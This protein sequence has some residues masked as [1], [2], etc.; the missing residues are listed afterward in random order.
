MWMLRNS[1]PQL[2]SSAI[3]S[4]VGFLHYSAGGRFVVV[5]LRSL[6]ESSESATDPK[7]Q[8]VRLPGS[9]SDGL[10]TRLHPLS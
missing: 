2:F 7:W 4:A 3:V 1:I 9:V 10:A 6:A 8:R 5:D